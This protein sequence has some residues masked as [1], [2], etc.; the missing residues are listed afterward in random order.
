MKRF[1]Y[2]FSIGLALLGSGEAQVLAAQPVEANASHEPTGLTLKLNSQ[3]AEQLRGDTLRFNATSADRY[4]YGLYSG[5]RTVVEMD[6]ST[7]QTDGGVRDVIN[8]DFNGSKA[9]IWYSDRGKSG[10]TGR[11]RHVRRCTA[12]ARTI[13]TIVGRTPTTSWGGAGSLAPADPGSMEAGVSCKVAT[14]GDYSGKCMCKCDHG[15]SPAG[16]LFCSG[17]YLTMQLGGEGCYVGVGCEAP[18]SACGN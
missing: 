18:L 5:Q 4:Q 16:A 2:T 15:W 7:S 10:S 9:Q 3:D 17:F 6:I 12:L 11:R 14:V 8:C 13:A 1:A